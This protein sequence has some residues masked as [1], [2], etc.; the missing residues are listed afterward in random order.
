MSELPISQLPMLEEQE[1]TGE[2]AQV[3]DDIKREVNIPFIPN[4]FRTLATS[5]PALAGTWNAELK[6]HMQTTLPMSLKT[7]ILF[8]I[9]AARQ[10]KYCSALHEVTCRTLGIDEETLGALV[11]DLDT[12]APRR[13]QEIIKFALKCAENSSSLTEADYDHVREQ[14][15]SDEELT[16][17]IALS[18]LGVYLV[19]LAGG[20]KVEVDSVFKQA[21]EG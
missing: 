12:L 11:K 2:V 5:P 7:M 6:I 18:A 9:A 19:I 17:I 8:S 15:V 13:V 10:C 1:A 14:G 21:L 16:E 3:F 4:F 20:L